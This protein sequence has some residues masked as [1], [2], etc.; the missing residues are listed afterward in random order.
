[1]FRL[2]KIR[3]FIESVF[4]ACFCWAIAGAVLFW[5]RDNIKVFL[6][7]P[8]DI[9]E[10]A[11]EDIKEG[12]RV[13]GS[14][15]LIYDYYCY[16]EE[17]GKIKSKEYLIPVGSKEYMGLVCKGSDM[18]EA[19]AV[20]QFYW[21]YLERKELS[22]DSVKSMKIKGTIMPLEGESFGV[23][24]QYI[25]QAE[26]TKG[27]KKH[28]LPY[29][30]MSGDIGGESKGGLILWTLLFLGMF[31][32][33]MACLVSGIKGSNLKELEKYCS[34][35]GDKEMYMQK[36]EAFYQAGIPV[37]GIR[38]DKQYFMGVKG[39]SV[40]FA[41]NGDLLWVYKNVVQHR[42]NGIPTGKTHSLVIKKKD[43]GE[44]NIKMGSEKASN[45]AI[46]YVVGQIPYLIAG[47]DEELK[48]MFNK[49]RMEM[50][51]IVAGRRQE[52]METNGDGL[53]AGS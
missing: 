32:L 47:Y 8:V 2:L 29:A 23:Y 13:K 40:F 14:I 37:Q 15:D 26:W 46:E 36:I 53:H 45:Q 43:G 11:A 12:V 24:N 9:N 49:R 18:K 22:S 27:Q 6:E 39:S 5:N 16:S 19:D 21:D 17:N 25:D 34:E 48:T 35:M 38:I 4:M 33:G 52:Y 31:A 1:M 41:E 7:K 51:D 28:F 50:V 42:V 10:L 3:H 44:F 30:V 20:M